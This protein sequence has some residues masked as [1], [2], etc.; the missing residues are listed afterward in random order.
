M[1]IVAL[2]LKHGRVPLAPREHLAFR[3]SDQ[4]DS[5]EAMRR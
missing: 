5:L 4:G 2:D 3:P 1:Q